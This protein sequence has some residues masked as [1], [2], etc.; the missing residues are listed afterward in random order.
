MNLY[1]VIDTALKIGLG[2]AISGI[3]T[4]RLARLGT[5]S[6]LKK[7]AWLDRRRAYEEAIDHGEKAFSS[8]RRFYSLAAGIIKKSEDLNIH[9][10]A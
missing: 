5:V 7:S 3:T 4:Y 9:L 1:D 8:W 10:T 2:A 6:D